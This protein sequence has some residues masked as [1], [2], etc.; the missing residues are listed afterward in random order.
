MLLQITLDPDSPIP[1][2]YQLQQHLRQQIGN[3]TLASGDVLPSEENLAADLGISRA[4]VR[5]AI[6]GLVQDGRLERRRNRGTRVTTPP[7]RQSLGGFY[8]FAHVMAELGIEQ[9]S[10]VLALRLAAPPA[11]VADVFSAGD[12]DTIVLERLRHAGET[13]LILETCWYPRLVGNC[14]FGADLTTAS[15]YDLLEAAAVVISRA[16]ESI[17]PI[18]LDSRQ[19]DLLGVR[20]GDPAFFV[21]RTSFAGQR[22]V[23]LRRSVIRGDRYLYSIDLPRSVLA[24]ARQSGEQQP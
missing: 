21:E 12:G 1:L 9:H 6:A 3:G 22:P 17:R 10:R 24:P 11:D 18:V 2:Y 14:L 8:S 4:T 5:Q 15:I 13:P 20:K 16:R 23:E 7:V 19:A